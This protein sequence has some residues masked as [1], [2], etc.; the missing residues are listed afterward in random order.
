MQIQSTVKVPRDHFNLDTA[1]TYKPTFK[2]K[3]KGS[4]KA[5]PFAF[6]RYYVTA[7]ADDRLA[8]NDLSRQQ[9]EAEL[10][11][12]LWLRYGMTPDRVDQLPQ[13]V[14]D[15]LI[16]GILE[17]REEQA[18]SHLLEVKRFSQVE[19]TDQDLHEPAQDP[20]EPIPN[21]GELVAQ[22]WTP[23]AA[24][25]HVEFLWNERAKAARTTPDDSR[26]FRHRVGNPVLAGHT[27]ASPRNNWPRL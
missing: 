15:R 8:N 3:R 6:Q 12:E 22:G 7:N 18:A 5:L 4:K 2:L 25:E 20:Q 10:E 27:N 19:L 1:K 9:T 21:A 26:D 11:Q 24:R 16:E 13:H 17:D 14:F 23:A